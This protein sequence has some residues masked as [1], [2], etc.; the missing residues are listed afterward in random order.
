MNLTNATYTL[1]SEQIA[2][3]VLAYSSRPI[4]PVSLR[5]CSLTLSRAAAAA[6]IA[7]ATW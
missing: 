7:N 1:V 4:M 2:G 6:T 5:S 3:N